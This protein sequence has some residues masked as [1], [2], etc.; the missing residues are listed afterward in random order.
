MNADKTETATSAE[1]EREVVSEGNA[2]KGESPEN[3]GNTESPENQE[4]TDS[5]VRTAVPGA[6]MSAEVRGEEA[7]KTTDMIDP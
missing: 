3:L 1:A 4:K 6:T 7:E 5:P 2:E